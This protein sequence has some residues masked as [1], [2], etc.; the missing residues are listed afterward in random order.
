MAVRQQAGT[1]TTGTPLHFT[2]LAAFLA[3]C[4]AAG[5]LGSVATTPN[6]P[7]WYA[8]LVKP[9]FTPPNVVFPIVWGLLYAMMAVAA[10]IAWRAGPS[11]GRTPAMQAFLLQLGLNVAWS[12][13]FFGWHSPLLGLAVIVLLFLAI[14]GTVL[15]FYRVSRAAAALMVP[16]LAWVGFASA[17]N[18][19][20]LRLN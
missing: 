5:W 17:L 20:I 12:W 1:P 8:G 14:L 11:P 4:A 2:M 3:L 15:L 16:Y 13:A 10:W 6:I 9:A 7:T 19:A 18:F